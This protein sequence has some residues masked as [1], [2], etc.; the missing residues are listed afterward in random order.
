MRT[1]Y[2]GRAA[3]LENKGEYES[4]LAD[5]QMVVLYYALEVDILNSMGS[6][7]REKLLDEAAKAYLAR[8]KCLD[9]L[10][11]QSAA[12]FDRERAEDLQ[13]SAKKL[14]SQATNTEAA[15][16]GKVEVINAWTAAVTLV[17]GGAS[18]RLEVGEQ[19]TISVPAGS[20][21]CEIQFGT[22]IRTATLQAGKRYTIR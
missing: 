19:K 4:A 22:I 15:P 3:A 21:S 5:H 8:S 11:R 16:A 10:G 12:Q 17:I 14:A 1:A 9:Q 2:S 18:Y 7:K 13:A 6:P 20:V